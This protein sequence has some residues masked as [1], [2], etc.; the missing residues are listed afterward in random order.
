MLIGMSSTGRNLDDQRVSVTRLDVRWH[1]LKRRLLPSGDTFSE[2]ETE[3]MNQNRSTH[4]EQDFVGCPGA[5]LK[6]G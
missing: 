5:A 2:E 6:R 3:D 4:L 1:S